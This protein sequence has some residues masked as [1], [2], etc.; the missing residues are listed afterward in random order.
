[1]IYK[2]LHRFYVIIYKNANKKITE[3]LSFHLL[4]NCFATCTFSS[5]FN[6]KYCFE[7]RIVVNILCCVISQNTKI[8]ENCYV[9]QTEH[10]GT[11]D[12]QIVKQFKCLRKCK[13]GTIW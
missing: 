9:K 1:M 6:R 4:L 8:A 11:P 13:Y 10:T 2:C 7:V 3:H 12:R 5:I